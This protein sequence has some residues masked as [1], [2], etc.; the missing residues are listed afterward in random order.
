MYNNDNYFL[1][2]VLNIVLLE[3]VLILQGI[4]ILIMYYRRRYRQ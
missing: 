4:P 1:N 2:V 3:S